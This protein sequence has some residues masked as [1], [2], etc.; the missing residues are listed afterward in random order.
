MQRDLFTDIHMVGVKQLEQCKQRVWALLCSA[1][2]SMSSGKKTCKSFISNKFCAV[3]GCLVYDKSTR[4][5]R[6][7]RRGTKRRLNL[8]FFLLL[9]CLRLDVCASVECG[10][11][12][13]A[14]SRHKTWLNL[15]IFSNNCVAGKTSF[16]IVF[17]ACR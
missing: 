2:V 10:K 3:F 16:G 4:T 1:A 15:N 12:I 14:N 7:R 9:S 17:N 8:F 13:N 5:K 11:R 6:T